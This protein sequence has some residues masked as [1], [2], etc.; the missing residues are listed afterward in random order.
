MKWII[1]NPVLAL[2]LALAFLAGFFR[3]RSAWLADRL[4]QAQA[5]AKAQKEDYDR[6]QEIRRRVS[7]DRDQRVRTLDDA[8]YRD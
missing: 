4:E 6:A 3:I 2:L 8:G 5:K 7:D 1:A